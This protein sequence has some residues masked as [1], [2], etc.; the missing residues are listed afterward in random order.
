MVLRNNF[1]SEFLY[2][3]AEIIHEKKISSDDFLYN[4]TFL[5]Y[6]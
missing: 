4:V 6:L 3:I 1:S 2:Q 5:Y